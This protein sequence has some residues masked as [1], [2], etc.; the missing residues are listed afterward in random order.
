MIY[1]VDGSLLAS[2]YDT[3][4]NVL[5]AVY[6]IDGNLLD[7]TVFADETTITDVFISSLTQQPQGGCIDDDGN[8]YV[9]FYNVGKLL[10]HNLS[11]GSESQKTFSGGTY[12]HANG[13]TYNPNTDCIYLA[14]MNDTGEVYVFDTS[15]NLVDTLYAQKGDGTVFN[16]WNIA[17]DRVGQRFVVMSAGSIYFFDDNFDLLTTGSYIVSDW[18]ETRQDIETEGTYIYALSYNLNT[19]CVFNMQG[20]LV[21]QII[22]TAFSGEPESMCYDWI[23]DVYYIEGKSSTYV[24]REAVFKD[25]N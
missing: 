18:A 8:V 2:A 15:L 9:C 22:N 7:G 13:M 6:D 16:C 10:K 20:R 11:T 5:G 14:S 21:K 1:D 17:Y 24:I 25:S 12:G 4:G 3:I 23:N 19:I